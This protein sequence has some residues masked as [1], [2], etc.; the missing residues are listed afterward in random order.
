MINVTIKS[1]NQNLI[2]TKLNSNLGIQYGTNA[3]SN[4]DTWEFINGIRI[5]DFHTF[6]GNPQWADTYVYISAMQFI[7]LSL[8][9]LMLFK[10]LSHST[11]SINRNV[12]LII[13]A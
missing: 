3:V 11:L 2:F 13:K 7:W 8:A 5:M 1:I 12:L 4:V 9:Q 6:G 10:Y